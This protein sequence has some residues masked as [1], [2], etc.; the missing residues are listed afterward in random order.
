MWEYLSLYSAR[1]D[2]KEVF[3]VK[4]YPERGNKIAED[5]LINQL[6]EEGWELFAIVPAYGGG[7][8]AINH[9]LYFRRTRGEQRTTRLDRYAVEE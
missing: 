3:N 6:A 5:V 2:G 7:G 9:Q 1:D 4:H 8:M